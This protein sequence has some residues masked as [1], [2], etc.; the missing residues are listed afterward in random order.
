MSLDLGP[1]PTGTPGPAPQGPAGPA[2]RPRPDGRPGTSP[3]P[4]RPSSPT[5]PAGALPRLGEQIRDLERY[6]AQALAVFDRDVD[7]DSLPD[8][9][10]HVQAVTEARLAL[11]FHLDSAMNALAR[12]AALP[13]PPAG[14]AVKLPPRPAASEGCA[15]PGGAGQSPVGPGEG[16][17]PSPAAAFL[18]SAA[19]ESDDGAVVAPVAGAD[20][21]PLGT[22]RP[23]G[24]VELSAPRSGL[25]RSTEGVASAL[26]ADG[27]FRLPRDVRDDQ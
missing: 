11:G 5:R 3:S 9:P 16:L 12:I 14:S 1:R 21:P 8:A 15:V 20:F 19:R 23:S 13:L 26:G 18:L 7:P 25:G 4:S 22:G 6:V 17:A 10:L 24:L 27:D 2:P